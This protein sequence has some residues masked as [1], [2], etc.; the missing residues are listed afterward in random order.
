M[1]IAADPQQILSHLTAITAGRSKQPR[2]FVEA[3]TTAILTALRAGYTGS[4]LYQAFVATGHP[5]PMS[6]R[7][8]RRYLARLRPQVSA[9]AS[10]PVTP[11]SAPIGGSEQPTPARPAAP[12]ATLH[13]DPLADDMDIH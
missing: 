2:A 4:D 8:F 12:P 13:W 6:L 7:Q 5:P 10:P 9:T 1:P 3:N 11:G